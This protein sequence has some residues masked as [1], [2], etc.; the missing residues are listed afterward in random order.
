MSVSSRRGGITLEALITVPLVLVTTLGIVGLARWCSYELTTI[1]AARVSARAAVA[2]AMAGEDSTHAAE[3]AAN[4][5][6]A[7]N[8]GVGDLCGPSASPGCAERAW[9]RRRD[10]GSASVS[11]GSSGS[12]LT[13][14]VTAQAPDQALLRLARIDGLPIQASGLMPRTE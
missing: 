6:E 13:V 11:I 7:L 4:G 12:H 3:V 10:A 9:R 1:Y 14:S 8:L 2:A 5:V